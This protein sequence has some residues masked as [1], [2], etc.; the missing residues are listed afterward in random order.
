MKLWNEVLNVVLKMIKPS[1]SD[2]NFIFKRNGWF[3][4]Y[5]HCYEGGSETAQPQ[6][7]SFPHLLA[8]LCRSLPGEQH[9]YHHCRLHPELFFIKNAFD[10]SAISIII[11][12][13]TNITV[14][15]TI[16]TNNSQASVS[17]DCPRGLTSRCHN[18]PLNIMKD[19]YIPEVLFF[20]F[21]CFFV[22]TPFKPWPNARSCSQI[23][24]Y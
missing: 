19:D 24:N 8:R 11:L 6:V 15:V 12:S 23:V 16:T 10:T 20:L 18:F 3:E 1:H 2:A 4:I 17:V 13:T 21:N 14:A 22:C 7:F 9:H 5:L